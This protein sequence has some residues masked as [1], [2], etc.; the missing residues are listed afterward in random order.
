MKGF[1]Q[2]EKGLANNLGWMK[3]F[4]DYPMVNMHKTTISG[5]FGGHLATCY[6]FVVIKAKGFAFDAYIDDT[7]RFDDAFR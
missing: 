5:F 2:K 6:Y 3:T 7:L 1:I 4:G